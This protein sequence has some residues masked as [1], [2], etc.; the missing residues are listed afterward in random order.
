MNDLWQHFKKLFKA[1]EN[2]SPNEPFIHEVIERTAEEI[3]SYDRWK[4]K[5]SK[6][7]LINW[8]DNEYF[9]YKTNPNDTDHAIDFLNTPSS[10]GFVVHFRKMNYNLAEI[11][12]LFD[13][14]KE[15]V[16]H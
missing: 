13:Y 2:S 5:F 4:N 9:R 12:H 7:R 1:S 16:L 10:K 14:F 6:Q 15:K 3:A 8:L 11:T